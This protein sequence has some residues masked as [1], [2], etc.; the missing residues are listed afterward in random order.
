MRHYRE[1]NGA[2]MAHV[3]LLHHWIFPRA[4]DGAKE[5]ANTPLCDGAP[6]A[7]FTRYAPAA[8]CLRR[9]SQA[10]R[11][12]PCRPCRTELHAQALLLVP[13]LEVRKARAPACTHTRVRALI[14]PSDGRYSP[15]PMDWP[16]QQ[17][18][19]LLALGAITVVFAKLFAFVSTSVRQ[20]ECHGKMPAAGEPIEA[21]AKPVSR[22]CFSLDRPSFFQIDPPGGK[23]WRPR[24]HRRAQSL[25][26]AASENLWGPLRG[27]TPSRRG[28]PDCERDSLA[29]FGDVGA[30]HV[31]RRDEC[32]SATLLRR[33]RGCDA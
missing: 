28:C 1:I 15:S 21:L 8:L 24:I 31:A 20:W 3:N 25:D 18:E 11:W 10:H 9:R 17:S 14:A 16:D 19:P 7:H 22:R 29:S 2:P 13:T 30:G 26:G 32:A 27:R 6:M 12:S 33:L 23:S 4:R 5:R